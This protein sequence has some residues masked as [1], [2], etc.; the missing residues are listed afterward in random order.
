M[1]TG[2]PLVDTLSP[3]QQQGEMGVVIICMSGHPPVNP[4]VHS[5]LHQLGQ[6]VKLRDKPSSHVTVAPTPAWP[7]EEKRLG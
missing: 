4:P 3:A 5:R 1:S 7:P 6:Q 2:Q